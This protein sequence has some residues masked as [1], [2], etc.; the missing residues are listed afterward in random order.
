MVDDILKYLSEDPFKNTNEDFHN[1][2]K[3][4]SFTTC[5]F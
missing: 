3:N 1:P 2:N 4:L 5:K